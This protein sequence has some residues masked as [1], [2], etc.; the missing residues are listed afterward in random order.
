MEIRETLVNRFYDYVAIPSQSCAN[1]GTK[2]PSTEGQWTWR[3][4]SKKDLERLGLEDI[5]L[6]EYG[7]L[8]AR[9]PAHL[10][11]GFT[12]KVPAV[13][14]CTHLDTVDVN[15]S[16]VVHPHMVKNYDGKD[17]VLNADQQIVM[18]T[19]DHPELLRY[20]GDDLIVTDGTSVLGSDNKAAVTNVV[21][22]LETLTSDPSLYHAI[23]MS[24][25]YLMRKWAYLGQ[26]ISTSAVF[27]S[28]LP[29]PSTAANSGK[30]STR[31][32]TPAAA[33]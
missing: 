8:T 7:V 18:T 28:T 11:A 19:K 29:I 5:H 25:L 31:P 14:F 2:V 3:G 17:L 4:P 10:P 1:G 6:S 30:S 27:L 12:K 15:L 26:S 32:L 24:P 23:S 22:A 13:G 16:P 33:K 9:L 21:T 20:Q